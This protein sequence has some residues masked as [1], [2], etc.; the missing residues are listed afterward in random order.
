[1]NI[2]ARPNILQLLLL[3]AASLVLLIPSPVEAQ[4]Q[5]PVGP[6]AVDMRVAL[7]RFKDDAGVALA[8]GVDSVNMPTRGL[9]LVGGAHWYPVG[10]GRVAL[11]LGGEILLSGATKTLAANED[12]PASV[13]G[14]AVRTRFSAISPQVSL[15][16]GTGRGWSYLT[17]GLGW[18]SFRTEREAAPV[19]DAESRPRVLNY[20]GGAR[21]FAREHVAFAV[22]L[23][24]YAVGAQVAATG[25]PAYPSMTLMVFSAGVAFK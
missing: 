21:W 20:G 25:R 14:P 8:L 6:F 13:E 18:A 17:G 7:P 4:T 10:K 15:N 12:D 5:E 23:R 22:D 9:G 1:M 3:L 19:A 16:F 24:F 11:G 2:I